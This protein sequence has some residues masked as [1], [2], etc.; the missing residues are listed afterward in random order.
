MEIIIKHFGNS[1]ITPSKIIELT[2]K[3]YDT[4][5]TVDV[6]NYKGL[7]DVNFIENLRQVADEL[8]EQNTLVN[9]LS[10]DLI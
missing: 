6:T 4:Q 5:F 10:S 1:R 9:K 2:F 3:N 7:V 8:E